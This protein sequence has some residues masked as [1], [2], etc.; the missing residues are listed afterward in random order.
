MLRKSEAFLRWQAQRK[1]KKHRR[2]N[3]W[4]KF[5]IWLLIQHWK[6][7][8]RWPLDGKPSFAFLK[9]FVEDDYVRGPSIIGN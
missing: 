9:T 3:N 6:A 4:I 8:G 1:R 5:K 7:E 2:R